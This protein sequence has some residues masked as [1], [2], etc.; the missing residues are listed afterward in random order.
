MADLQPFTQKQYSEI[1]EALDAALA[2]FERSTPDAEAALEA[3]VC[4]HYFKIWRGMTPRKTLT[5]G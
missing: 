4:N 2:V 5:N 1:V 3:F